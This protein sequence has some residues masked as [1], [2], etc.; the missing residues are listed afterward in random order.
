MIKIK[1]SKK[2]FSSTGSMVLDVDFNI[3]RNSFVA[4]TGLSGSGKTTLLRCLAGLTRPDSGSITFD[5]K[6]LYDSEKKISVP[7]RK[8]NIGFVFQDYALF[9]NMTLRENIKYAC[10]N[11]R[12]TDEFIRMAELEGVSG[13][14]PDNLSSGQ[15]QRCALLRAVSRKPEILLLDEPFSAL[16]GSTKK[17]F[18]SELARWQSI[19]NLTVVLVSHDRSEVVKL[20]ERVIQLNN[21]TIES[22]ISH[23]NGCAGRIAAL[24]AAARRVS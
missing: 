18:H 7:S 19:F 1:L 2:L 17:I 6:I 5:D 21:G 15:K 12:R 8:R 4:V 20:T 3:E 9:P 13:L 22:D 24:Q 16:D 14:Y 10:G 23:R 11:Y